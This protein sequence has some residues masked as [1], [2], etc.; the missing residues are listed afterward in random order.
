MFEALGQQAV[1][2]ADTF[3]HRDLVAAVRSFAAAADADQDLCAA[4]SPGLFIEL[5][6]QALL[7]AERFDPRQLA[8]LLRSYARLRLHRGCTDL[9]HALAQQTIL[10]A[11]RFRPSDLALAAGSFSK[12]QY[13]EPGV[14]TALAAEVDRQADSLSPRDIAELAQAF[15][16]APLGQR[17]HGD[18]PYPRLAAAASIRLAEF[19][20]RDLATLVAAVSGIDAGSGSVELSELLEAAAAVIKRRA[21]TFPRA[22][23]LALALRAYAASRTEF[24][25]AAVATLAPELTRRMS[26]LSASE[27]IVMLAVLAE[28]L[29]DDAGEAGSAEARL[30]EVLVERLAE[31]SDRLSAR[32]VVTLL[33]AAGTQVPSTMPS[34]GALLAAL[35]RPLIRHIAAL[36]MEDLRH[37]QRVYRAADDSEFVDGNS[38][39]GPASCGVLA[40]VEQQLALLGVAAYQ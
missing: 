8:A 6:Q 38:G 9:F 3:S 23:D 1:L 16:L 27:V 7:M 33:S 15:A 24:A 17:H 40:A 36:D 20:P 37:A 29:A 21:S 25:A 12:L 4:L 26:E 31:D 32:S 35:S 19:A 2:I 34:R 28:R 18:A 5:G 14:Y 22:A 30:V 11:H 13:A 10:K 39:S